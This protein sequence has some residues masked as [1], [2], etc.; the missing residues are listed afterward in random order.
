MIRI[1]IV[2]NHSVEENILEAFSREGVGKFYTKYPNVFGVGNSGPRMGD[3]VWPEENLALVVWCEEDEAQGIARAVDAVKKQFPDEGIRVFGLPGPRFPPAAFYPGQAQAAQA[4]QAAQDPAASAFQ[5]VPRYNAPQPS[6][7]PL[8]PIAPPPPIPAHAPPVY[9][10][11]GVYAA[12]SSPGIN[13]EYDGQNM[14]E[15]H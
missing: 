13:A 1:E 11:P 10:S 14:D 15:E 3:A 12:A 8:E 4:G 5:P 7:P 6:R 9:P 2:A